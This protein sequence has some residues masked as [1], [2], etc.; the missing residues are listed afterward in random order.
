MSSP[1][2][3]IK[4]TAIG[5]SGI[6]TFALYVSHLQ[7]ESTLKKGLALLPTLLSLGVALFDSLLWRAPG[8]LAL[9][10]RPRIDGLWRVTLKPDARSAAVAG[11]ARGP[12][13]AYVIIEQRYWSISVT[14]FTEQS[15]SYSRATTFIKRQDSERRIL[16]FTYD[17]APSREHIERSPRHAGACELTVPR[18]SPS[19]LSGVY[20]TDRFTAGDMTLELLDRTTN[21]ETFEAVQVHLS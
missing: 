3:L 19:A 11:A 14:Q 9:H 7:L 1:S 16:S 12:I 6:Y 18:G 5:V 20:F 10:K 4:V 2:R 8:M 17:N 21:H 15:A 13:L